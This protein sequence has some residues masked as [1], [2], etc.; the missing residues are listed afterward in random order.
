[1]PEERCREYRLIEDLRVSQRV[2]WPSWASVVSD[3]VQCTTYGEEKAC[4][5]TFCQN[6]YV[7]VMSADVDKEKEC[8]DDS[9]VNLVVQSYVKR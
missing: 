7:Y 9:L 1:M 4:D 5:G 3:R 6:L 8:V 2:Y